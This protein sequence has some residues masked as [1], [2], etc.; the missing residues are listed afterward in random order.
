MAWPP[1][2][3]PWHLAVSGAFSWLMLG[4]VAA[5]AGI[6]WFTP[7]VLLVMYL[8][9]QVMFQGTRRNAGYRG[10]GVTGSSFR[11]AALALLGCWRVRDR[12][13]PIAGHGSFRSCRRGFSR[14]GR[15]GC[16]RSRRSSG[17]RRRC[18]CRNRS[19]GLIAEAFT[20]PG[21]R[22]RRLDGLLAAVHA[23]Q[24]DVVELLVDEQLAARVA[25]LSGRAI[26]VPSVSNMPKDVGLH[27]ARLWPAHKALI[28][29]AAVDSR[30]RGLPACAGPKRTRVTGPVA[31]RASLGPRR[32][33][34]GRH[35]P[36]SAECA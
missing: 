14:P 24:L 25:V 12:I 29:D 6:S 11:R 23:D 8:F 16:S 1:T 9:L 31:V 21:P 33:L 34:L 28:C 2:L 20:Q 27:G 13:D 15:P 17:P 35:C 19:T 32:V 5:N 18:T 10:E 4:I 3:D 26:E 30:R 22:D 36:C 7:I